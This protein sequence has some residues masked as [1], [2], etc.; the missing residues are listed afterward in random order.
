MVASLPPQVCRRPSGAGKTT[1]LDLLANRKTTG[2]S[3]EGEIKFAGT[4]PTLS[5]MCR[6]TGYVEQFGMSDLQSGGR[7]ADA[8]PQSHMV[9]GRVH[10]YDGMGQVLEVWLQFWCR[11]FYFWAEG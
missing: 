3:A 8:A 4:R 10:T 5:F 1:L 6:F 11:G 9:H 2:K 7:A